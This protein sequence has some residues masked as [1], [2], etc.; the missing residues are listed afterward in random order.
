MGVKST[1]KQIRCRLSRDYCYGEMSRSGHALMLFCEGKGVDIG[2]SGMKCV[3]LRC[4]RCPRYFEG[5]SVER[6]LRYIR[7]QRVPNIRKVN[8]GWPEWRCKTLGEPLATN[9]KCEAT[10]DGVTIGGTLTEEGEEMLL[11][12]TRRQIANMSDQEAADILRKLLAGV[13]FPRGN[14]KST[15]TLR[16]IRAISKGIEALEKGENYE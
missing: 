12:E 4:T 16:L 13:Q 6:Y 2:D 1:I 15:Q 11:D 5:F 10:D 3:P 9:C 8:D 7:A 14:G